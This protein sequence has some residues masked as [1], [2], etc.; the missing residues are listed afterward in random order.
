MLSF[1]KQNLPHTKPEL[2]HDLGRAI[3]RQLRWRLGAACGLIRTEF[4]DALLIDV[5]VTTPVGRAI[6]IYG[7]WDYALT[8][9][10]DTLLE[11]GMCFF[12]VGAN[13]G[14]FSLLA[15]RRCSRVFAFD[16][17]PAIYRQLCSNVALNPGLNIHPFDLALSDQSGP[18][19][20]W[21]ANGAE[22]NGNSS[23]QRCDNSVQISVQA[24]TL[25]AFVAEHRIPKIDVMKIDVEGAEDA[26]FRGGGDALAS[27]APDIV[28]EALPGSHAG[29]LLLPFGYRIYEFRHQRAYQ[30]RNLFASRRPLTAA[31]A[32]HLR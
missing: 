11:P 23:L 13:V 2:W 8:R 3:P 5:D 31:L 4:D 9:L 30:A 17:A 15:A 12:D 18:V 26:V 14:Y 7:C 21:V 20:F 22:Q 24:S 32:A 10:L 28:F 25:D 16:P 19:D 1:L 29:D 27:S 6:Y